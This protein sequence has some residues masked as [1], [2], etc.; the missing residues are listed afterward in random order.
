MVFNCK[1]RT[2]TLYFA[3]FCF[4]QKQPSGH[5]H[6]DAASIT[7]CWQGIEIFVDPGSY[8][9]TP[10]AWWRNQFRSATM[11]NS[12]YLKDIE[13]IVFD[14]RVFALNISE[15][16]FQ[17]AWINE[18]EWT[19]QTSH[20]LYKDMFGLNA[21][22]TIIFEP[23]EQHVIITDQWRSNYA[24]DE[25]SLISAWNFTLNEQLRA[26]HEDNHIVITHKGIPLAYF[27]ST[28]TFTVEDSWRSTAYGTKIATQCL[29]AG[30]NMV[31]NDQV[32]SSLRFIS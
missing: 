6:N 1:N 14:Q 31:N 10:S 21:R 13:P 25:I 19:L 30:V 22:R 9:Y 4:N 8:L 15:H 16:T 2:N 5:H 27:S 20:S 7:L 17:N 3:T 29:R 32:I 11:H 24:C 18:D 12:F 23:N 26:Q 28:I